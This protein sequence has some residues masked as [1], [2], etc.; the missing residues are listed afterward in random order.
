M[1]TM[2]KRICAAAMTGVM[3]V[4]LAGC[5]GNSTPLQEVKLRRHLVTMW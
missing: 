5:A 4:S 1:K 2:M 3:A